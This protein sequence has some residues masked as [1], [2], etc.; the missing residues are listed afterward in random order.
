M[1]YGWRSICLFIIYNKQRTQFSFNII[2]LFEY[3]KWFL[4]NQ[5]T[6]RVFFSDYF[7]FFDIIVYKRQVKKVIEMRLWTIIY[8]RAVKC[9]L[10]DFKNIFWSGLFFRHFRK[11]NRSQISIY[12]MIWALRAHNRLLLINC[13]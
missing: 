9:S 6:V 8:L 2:Y 4:I 13:F 3:E 10:S 7:C 11:Y 12:Q 5:I 1:A